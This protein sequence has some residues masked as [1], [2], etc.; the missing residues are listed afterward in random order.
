MAPDVLHQVTKFGTVLKTIVFTRN[1][2]FQ[3]LLRYALHMGI[4]GVERSL[5]SQNIYNACCTPHTNFLKLTVLVVFVSLTT[6]LEI[7]GKRES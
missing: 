2:W 7:S 6:N 4:Q 3:V 1:N 5:D